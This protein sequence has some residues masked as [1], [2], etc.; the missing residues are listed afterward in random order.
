MAALKYLLVKEVKQFKNNSFLPKLVVMFPLIVMLVMPWVATLDIK[1][2]RIAIVDHNKST[3]SERLLQKI[4][5]SDYFI[6]DSYSDTYNDALEHVESGDADLILEIPSDMEHNVV[7]GNP[8]SVFI[9]ANAV[10]SN[11]SG[12]GSGYLNSIISDFSTQ[13][14]DDK[15]IVMQKPIDLRVQFRYNPHLNYRLFMAPALMIV[16]LILLCGFLPTLNIVA[17]KESGTIEQINVTPVSKSEFILSKMIFYGILGLLIFTLSFII[18]RLVYGIA[19][20]GGVAVIYAAAI[21][22]IIFMSGLG[23]IISNY[24]NTLQQAVF[25]MFFCMIV[26]ML[27]SG[28]FTPVNSMTSWAQKLTYAIPPRY[29]VE[30]MRS[31]CLKGSTFADLGFEFL[32]LSL[33]AIGVNGIAVTSYRKQQ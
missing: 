10:N 5:A 20:Y 24:S 26:F 16:I 2:V 17:E 32:M 30:I 12:M 22:F 1:E 25:L 19:P 4:K 11:K 14:Q 29:F 7:R 31:V 8:V 27:M 6:I 23:L 18:G 9:A 3:M 33:F 21:L 15:G 28:V 13:L